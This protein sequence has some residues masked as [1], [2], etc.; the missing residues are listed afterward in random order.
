MAETIEELKS[1]LKDAGWR[2][3]KKPTRSHMDRCDWYAWQPKRPDEWPDCD[4]NDKPPSLTLQPSCI[5]VNDRLHTS[6]EFDLCGEKHGRWHALKVY[7][8]KLDE[9]MDAIPKATA[10]LGAAWKAIAAQEQKT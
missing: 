10:H 6:V 2:I 1:E 8:I 9:A 7:S 4:C 5:E 3:D